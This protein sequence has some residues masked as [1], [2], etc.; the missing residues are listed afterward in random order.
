MQIPVEYTFG[1]LTDTIEP[2][3]LVSLS[4]PAGTQ[5]ISAFVMNAEIPV[6]QP[7]GGAKLSTDDLTVSWSAG[8]AEF[9]YLASTGDDF[10][11]VADY[12]G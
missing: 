11:C 10:L 6:D 2:E 7:G 12:I 9:R 1:R 5:I 8:G 4:A 3:G